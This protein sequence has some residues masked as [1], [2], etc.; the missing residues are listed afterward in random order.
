MN[1]LRSA[2]LKRTVGAGGSPATADAN[3]LDLAYFGV[4]VLVEKWKGELL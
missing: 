2:C 1:K 3:Y 4:I